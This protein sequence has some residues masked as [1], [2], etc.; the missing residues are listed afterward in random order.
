MSWGLGAG[1]ECR[2][3]PRQ[4]EGKEM[5]PLWFLYD[6][7]ERRLVLGQD[8]GP[9]LDADAHRVGPGWQLKEYYSESD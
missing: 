8:K 7:K 5:W 3:P 4:K 2:E 9:F 1:A 6:A